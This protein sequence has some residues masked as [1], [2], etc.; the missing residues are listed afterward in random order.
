[1]QKTVNII[2]GIILTYKPNKKQRELL[3]AFNT[4][5]CISK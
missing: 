2:I 1:M 5:Y 4:Q 3:Q